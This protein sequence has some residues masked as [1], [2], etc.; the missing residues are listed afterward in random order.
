MDCLLRAA[1]EEFLG[2]IPQVIIDSALLCICTSYQADDA[3][4]ELLS[5]VLTKMKSSTCVLQSPN[6]SLK[7]ALVR[8]VEKMD[9]LRAVESSKVLCEH[10]ELQFRLA[11]VTAASN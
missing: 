5:P 6:P 7:G 4:I 3:M 2:V 10:I 8:V 9:V 11:T 1:A